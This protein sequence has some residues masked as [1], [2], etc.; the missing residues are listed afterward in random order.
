MWQGF[1]GLFFSR[2]ILELRYANDTPL[3]VDL[4]LGQFLSPVISGL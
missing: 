3:F 4:N 1:Q 2:G